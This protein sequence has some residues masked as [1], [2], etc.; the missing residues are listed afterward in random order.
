MKHSSEWVIR[1]GDGTNESHK[2]I[3]DSLDILWRYTSEL[4]YEDDIDIELKSSHIIPNMKEIKDAWYKNVKEIFSLATLTIPDNNWEYGEGRR[5][6][7]SEHLGYILTELQ[8]MQR[9]YPG[10]EW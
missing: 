1:L 5:G 9:A 8:Y 4:F 3:Q 6:V 10:M 2:R 7:H